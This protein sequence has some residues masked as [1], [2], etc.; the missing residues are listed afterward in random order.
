MDEISEKKLINFQLENLLQMLEESNEN[1]K[2]IE[3]F[4]WFVETVYNEYQ[5]QKGLYKK[6]INELFNIK[7]LNNVAYL[8]SAKDICSYF[9]DCSCGKIYNET[10][11]TNEYRKKH[12]KQLN[13]D[14][15]ISLMEDFEHCL[16]HADITKK[17]F[18]IQ[19]INEFINKI[20]K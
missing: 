2:T 15:P 13:V 1:N 20:H 16:K 14:I 3:K 17:Q 6:C 19:S 5:T 8:E 7:D 9:Y 11:Y 10:I 4:K 18:V 12:Y